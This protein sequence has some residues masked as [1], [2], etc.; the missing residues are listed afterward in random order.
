MKYICNLCYRLEKLYLAYT[1]LILG[2]NIK[3]ATNKTKR[4]K[5]HN[6]NNNNASGPYTVMFLIAVDVVVAAAAVTVAYT[7]WAQFSQT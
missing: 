4:K 3:H 7:H 5:N 6:N 2:G 1:D